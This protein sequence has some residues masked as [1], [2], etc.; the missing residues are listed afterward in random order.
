MIQKYLRLLSYENACKVIDFINTDKN[1]YA[2]IQTGGIS[3]Q[4]SE[5]NWDT[6][7]AFI[8]SLGVRY[9]ICTEEPYKMVQQIVH[10]LKKKGVIK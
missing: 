5:Q 4:V 9:E 7:L 6:V 3:I 2:S 1:D 8:E 10:D